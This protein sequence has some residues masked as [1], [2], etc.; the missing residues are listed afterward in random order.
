MTKRLVRFCCRSLEI[1]AFVFVVSG[2]LFLMFYFGGDETTSPSDK[3]QA[4]L[5][6]VVLLAV[7]FISFACGI[8]LAAKSGILYSKFTK[9]F[10]FPPLLTDCETY[11][12]CCAP[13]QRHKGGWAVASK[14]PPLPPIREE[15]AKGLAEE[16]GDPEQVYTLASILSPSEPPPPPLT[17]KQLQSRGVN[18]G[19]LPRTKGHYFV[20]DHPVPRSHDGHLCSFHTV[21]QDRTKLPPA[22]PLTDRQ[23]ESLGKNYRGVLEGTGQAEYTRYQVGADPEKPSGSQEASAPKRETFKSFVNRMHSRCT[24]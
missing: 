20:S 14:Q 11:G 3:K 21:F 24:P 8:T 10:S 4:V 23:I 18:Y 15:Q 19:G 7:G 22:P 13:Q 12:S 1:L 5:L 17:D 6:G 2:A 9:S 16:S